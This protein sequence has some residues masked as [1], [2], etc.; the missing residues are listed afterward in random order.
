MSMDSEFDP[1]D[2]VGLTTVKGKV[3]EKGGW[4]VGYDPSTGRTTL[5]KKLSPEE[6]QEWR[7]QQQLQCSGP[8]DMFRS[9][10]ESLP[11]GHTN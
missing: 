3:F 1:K 11:N 4:L 5:L 6:A 9:R 8:D 7:S 10:T 2:C